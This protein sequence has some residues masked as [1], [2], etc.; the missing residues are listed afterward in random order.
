MESAF[1]YEIRIGTAHTPVHR[2]HFASVRVVNG[3][4]G[5]PHWGNATREPMRASQQWRLARYVEAKLFFFPVPVTAA[6][7]LTTDIDVVLQR[8]EVFETEVLEIGIT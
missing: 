8:E 3:K 1:E 7:I 2:R 6:V 4:R 5:P